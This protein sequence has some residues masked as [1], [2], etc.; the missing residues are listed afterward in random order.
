M[1]R[2][3]R[4]IFWVGAL[5]LEFLS[6]FMLFVTL[7]SL[8]DTLEQWRDEW[9]PLIAQWQGHWLSYVALFCIPAPFAVVF[10]VDRIKRRLLRKSEARTQ[11]RYTDWMG[12]TYIVGQFV[13]PS[14]MRKGE[15]ERAVVLITVEQDILRRF[16]ETCPQGKISGG[17]QGDVAARYD[18]RLLRQWLIYNAAHLLSHKRAEL[19]WPPKVR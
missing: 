4:G 5:L 3:K 18:V 2:G 12:A 11:S 17:D 7:P 10:F 19:H 14:F 16:E 15:L 8:P 6:L 1:M 9:L 13:Q